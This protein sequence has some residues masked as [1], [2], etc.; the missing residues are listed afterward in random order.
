MAATFVVE[1]GTG[2][3]T[4]NAY[5]SVADATTYFENYSD[6]SAWD[7]A[8]TADQET[9]LRMATQ[10]IDN[11]FRGRWKGTPILGTQRLAWPR[12]GVV[13]EEG[14]GVDDASIPER[15]EEATA[16]M[17]LR[18]LADASVTDIE[19]DTDLTTQ[20]VSE[21][22]KVDVLETETHYAPGG[23]RVGTAYP[24]VGMLLAGL[25]RSSNYVTRIG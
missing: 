3:A 9:A 17:A 22:K 6:P 21:R 8:S 4:A 20:V 10:W 12:S 11:R 5:V 18:F 23:K 2:L 14:F 25:L 7:L 16:E 15:I 24:K 13:N 19:T 1:D